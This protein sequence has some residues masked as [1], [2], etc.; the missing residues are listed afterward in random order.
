QQ[1]TRGPAD[2][3]GEGTPPLGIVRDLV[4]HSI[5]CE[6][7]GRIVL[8]AQDGSRIENV[9]LDN[10]HLRIPEIEDPATTVPAARSMQLSNF[11]PETRAARAALVADN[12][13]GLD[14]R[15]VRVSW[16]DTP[17]VPMEATCLR[18]CE[19]VRIES[20]ALSSCHPRHL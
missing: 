13:D 17:E 10:I 11:N 9:S 20:P 19:N 2:S 3:D 6:T 15:D 16:P 5:L 12:V 1:W 8:T 4:F 18:R 14:V 7:R